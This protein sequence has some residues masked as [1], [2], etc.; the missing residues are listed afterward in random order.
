MIKNAFLSAAARA[1]IATA[2]VGG[3]VATTSVAVAATLSPEAKAKAVADLKAALAVATTKAQ[4]VAALN[5]AAAAGLTKADVLTTIQTVQAEAT[6][7]NNT[8]LATVLAPIADTIQTAAN[9]S[10]DTVITFTTSTTQTNTNTSTADN[11]QPGS[12]SNGTSDTGG[13]TTVVVY[14][15]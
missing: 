12:T 8:V 15:G 5:T 9:T 14:V 13:N 6:A 2:V 4:V 1:L 11:G 10:G 7:N 3:V